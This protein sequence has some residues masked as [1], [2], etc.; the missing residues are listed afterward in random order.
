MKSQAQS[1]DNTTRAMSGERQWR[2]D[3]PKSFL[4]NP[5]TSAVAERLY[6]DKPEDL[7]AM[8]AFADVLD[9]ADMRVRGKASA[10]QWRRRS[11]FQQMSGLAT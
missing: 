10:W 1:T 6:R 8:R 5:A 3:W 9:N 4:D 11:N 7:Q 2:G